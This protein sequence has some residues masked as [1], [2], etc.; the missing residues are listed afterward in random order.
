[1]PLEDLPLPPPNQKPFVLPPQTEIQ[2]PPPPPPP[3]PPKPITPPPQP[4]PIPP[5][6]PIPKPIPPPP[7]KP[8]ISPEPKR[9]HEPLGP[10]IG[11]G[12]IVL[13]LLLGAFYLWGKYLNNLE[14]DSVPYIPSDQSVE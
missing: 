7:P 9:V 14:K 8:K 10:T 5:P 3:P 12:V 1:M 11:I 6:P 13:L 4:P 2:P